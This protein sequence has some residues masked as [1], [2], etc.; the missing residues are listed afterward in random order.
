MDGYSPEFRAVLRRIVARDLLED[1]R[2]ISPSNPTTDMGKPNESQMAA[3]QDA[4][5]QLKRGATQ[6]AEDLVAEDNDPMA[7]L[8]RAMA[9]LRQM[10]LRGDKGTEDYDSMLQIIKSMAGGSQ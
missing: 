8:L 5:R 2:S 4:P 7:D 9:N 6:T 1:T 3:S 10:K